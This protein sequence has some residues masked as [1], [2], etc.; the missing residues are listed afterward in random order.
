MCDAEEWLLDEINELKERVEELEIEL[1]L[2]EGAFF[3]VEKHIINPIRR[4]NF[5]S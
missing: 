2:A 1:M 5:K 4:G 3:E